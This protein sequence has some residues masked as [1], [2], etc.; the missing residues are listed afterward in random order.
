MKKTIIALL[1]LGSAAMGVTL[2]DAVATGSDASQITLSEAT[3]S[4]TAIATVDVDALKAVMA[5]GADL[6]KYTLI[7]FE[8]VGDGADIGIQTNY[9]SANN[10]INTSG[11]Y[12]VWNGT[13]AYGFGMGSGFENAGFWTNA[14]AAAVTLTYSYDTGTTGTFTLMDSNGKVLQEVGGT[15]STSLKSSTA[16]YDAVTFD[17]SIV[18]STYVFNQA[19]TVEEAKTLAQAALVKTGTVPEPTTATLSLLA[20]AG[21][22]A[23]RRRK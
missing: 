5:K 14:A 16:T 11:L 10:K 21:L 12:G 7:N 2:E 22:A 9:G 15:F 23:R 3:A 20:L 18:E 13:G 4:F 17:G 6:G 1:A 8:S 19:V